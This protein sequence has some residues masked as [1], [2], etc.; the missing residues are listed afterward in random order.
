M[1]QVGDIVSNNFEVI[2]VSNKG[3][4]TMYYD[5]KRKRKFFTS[6]GAM[7]RDHRVK[8]HFRRTKNGKVTNVKPHNRRRFKKN[9]PKRR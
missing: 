7:V 8:G 3:I 2:E 4:P 5:I 6:Y 1:A 9:A